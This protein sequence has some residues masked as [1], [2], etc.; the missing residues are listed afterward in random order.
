MI[1]TYPTRATGVGNHDHVTG[2]DVP[3]SKRALD[4]N[5]AN[6]FP[7]RVTISG[8][9]SGTAVSDFKQVASLAASTV[10]NHDYTAV[11]TFRTSAIHACASGLI[12]VE[13][14]FNGALTFVGFNSTNEPNVLIPIAEDSDIS[15]GQVV[16]VAVTNRETV[17]QDVYSTIVGEEV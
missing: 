11:G 4:V 16:R 10:D 15:A 2:T 9:T 3:G 1:K 13:V 7:I 6:E 5:V 17:A 8:A 14:Y 12:K